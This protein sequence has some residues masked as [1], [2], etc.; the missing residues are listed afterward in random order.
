MCLYMGLSIPLTLY[1]HRKVAS[2][3]YDSK[4]TFIIN[5]KAPFNL[6]QLDIC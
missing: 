2:Y 5:A 1:V 4:C 6:Q 3:Q